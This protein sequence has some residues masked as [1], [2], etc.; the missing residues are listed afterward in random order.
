MVYHG[1]YRPF[2]RG[3]SD[4]R[5]LTSAVRG[6]SSPSLRS[7]SPNTSSTTDA[8]TQTGGTA[9]SVLGVAAPA[10]V[11]LD[12]ELD[13]PVDELGVGDSG[14]LPELRV[15]RDRREARHRVGLVA[16]EPATALLEEE[17]DAGEAVPA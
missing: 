3:N 17:I 11:A 14:R 6:Q 15:H 10:G 16:E 9:P 13:Q 12:G 7:V 5:R 4:R 8:V 2:G 1:G